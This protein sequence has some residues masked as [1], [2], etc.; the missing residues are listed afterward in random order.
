MKSI[1]TSIVERLGDRLQVMMEY[2]LRGEASYFW[3]FF[4]D[5]QG[6]QWNTIKYFTGG[7][8]SL[9]GVLN[10]TVKPRKFG[11]FS[12]NPKINTRCSVISN[13]LSVL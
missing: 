2:L 9:R 5:S 1:T 10:C 8:T 12:S 4:Y 7:M 11:S 13:L 3:F 6:V